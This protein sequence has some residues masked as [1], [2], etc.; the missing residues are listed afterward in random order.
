MAK[1]Y[2]SSHHRVSP[3]RLKD[4]S[5]PGHIRFL[6]LWL[7]DPHQRIISTANVPPQRLDWWVESAFG[8]SPESKENALSR[9]PA[10][11]V[12]L[13]REV[14]A[15]L[16][17]PGKPGTGRGSRW[18]LPAELMSMIKSQFTGDLPMSEREAR[19]YRTQL[20][21]ERTSIQ[22]TTHREWIANRH[23]S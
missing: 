19:D 7:V 17:E 5:K 2:I 14:G 16:G 15:D 12:E 8:K 3:F 10:E 20:E 11:L 22:K 4:H 9:V 23:F 18:K 21:L 1:P 6:T 13:L